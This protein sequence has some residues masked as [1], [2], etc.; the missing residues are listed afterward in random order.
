MTYLLQAGIR[1]AAQ[2]LSRTTT[3]AYFLRSTIPLGNPVQQLLKANPKS[4]IANLVLQTCSEFNPSSRR[5]TAYRKEPI[6]SS[7]S[8]AM[9]K[10]F[11]RKIP[12]SSLY[13][14]RPTWWLESRF[15]FSF[16]E[17]FNPANQEFGVLRVLNDDLVQP[18]A[19]FGTHPHR[20]MEIITYV[21]DGQLSH[22][23]S[24]GTEETLGR[25]C[26]QYMSAGTGVTHSEMNHSNHLQRFLQIWVKPN[27]RGLK[28]NYGSR[29]FSKSDRHNKLQQV[30]TSYAHYGSDKDAGSGLIP[31]NQDV[32]IFVS[33]MNGVTDGS[34]APSAAAKSLDYT[35]QKKRQM[36]LVCIEGGLTVSSVE[37][38]LSET[39]SARDALEVA[40]PRSGNLPLKIQPDV[41]SGAHFLFLEMERT[42]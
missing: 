19:G 21:V 14:S 6:R 4:S 38:G 5:T 42:V 35:L 20:D 7:S 25:G 22:K 37:S 3:T 8:T 30:V 18:N 32:N 41:A 28:P 29:T 17:Y 16:A 34:V 9:E 1:P 2:A 33:E 31:V 26:V 23:D 10:A 39:L 27:A 11:V 40:A 15:H 12:S 13:V 24:M 36:Y